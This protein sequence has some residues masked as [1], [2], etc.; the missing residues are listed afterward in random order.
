[1]YQNLRITVGSNNDNTILSTQN[2]ENIIHSPNSASSSC[3]ELFLTLTSSLYSIVEGL[4]LEIIMKLLIVKILLPCSFQAQLGGLVEVYHLKK[5]GTKKKKNTKTKLDKKPTQTG[6]R[7][8]HR[9]WCW[10]NSLT[11]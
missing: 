11:H 9:H 7:K 3:S 5:H 8:S 6:I 4:N 1:M 10:E 2:H